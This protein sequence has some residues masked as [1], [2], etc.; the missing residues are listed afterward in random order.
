[1]QVL[2]LQLFGRNHVAV[3]AVPHTGRGAWTDG[4]TEEL[5]H[6]SF[7]EVVDVRLAESPQVSVPALINMAYGILKLSLP[8]E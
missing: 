6:Q 1:M 5:P 3:S 7:R 4:Q 2:N 8:S